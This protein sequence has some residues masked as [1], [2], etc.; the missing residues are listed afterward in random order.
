MKDLSKREI[1]VMDILWEL[2]RSSVR[3]IAE[4]IKSEQKLAYTTVATLLQRL[5]DKGFVARVEEGIGYMYTPKLSKEVYTKNM[6]SS[7]LT[8]FIGSFGDIGIASFAESIEKLPEEK[9]AYFLKLLDE[10]DKNK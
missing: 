1:E 10:Y 3:D 2:K 4:R 7:F 6:A 9:R 8:R 5:Y